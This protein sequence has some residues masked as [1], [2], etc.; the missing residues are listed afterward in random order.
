M[1]T[2]GWAGGKRKPRE[3]GVHGRDPCLPVR[4]RRPEE[5]VPVLG[6]LRGPGL[7]G[8]RANLTETIQRRTR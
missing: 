8:S 1:R 7:R 5:K 4:R 3:C 2:R 6:F